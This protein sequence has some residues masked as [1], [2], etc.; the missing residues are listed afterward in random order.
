MRKKSLLLLLVE[1]S[2]CTTKKMQMVMEVMVSTR[3]H[4]VQEEITV[5]RY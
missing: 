3:K 1:I 2:K 5:M 4:V